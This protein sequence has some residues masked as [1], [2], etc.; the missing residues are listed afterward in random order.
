MSKIYKLDLLIAI[1][2]FCIVAAEMMGT[3]TF[4][5]TNFSW[6]QLNASVAILFIPLIYSINDII[7]EVYGKERARSVVRSGLVVIVLIIIFSAIATTLPPSARFAGTESAY[8]TIFHASLRISAASLTAFIIAQ[9]ADI[10]IFSRLKDKMKNHAL[11]F[12]NNVSNIIALFLDTIVFM[13][14]AFYSFDKPFSDNW[15]FIMSLVIPYWLIK[16]AMSVLDTPFVYAG[17]WWL[18]KDKIAKTSK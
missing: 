13:V 15:A 7:I 10:Y 2:I 17:V 14:L 9:I 8:D 18:K 6:M 3:K 12:R 11:W 1:Y 16:C 4:P 5:L